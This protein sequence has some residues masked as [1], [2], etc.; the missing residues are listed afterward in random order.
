M[1]Q[2]GSLI[3]KQFRVTTLVTEKFLKFSRKPK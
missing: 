2:M 1:R 3:C